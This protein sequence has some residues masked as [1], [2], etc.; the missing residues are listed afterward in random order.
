MSDINKTPEAPVGAN[1]PITTKPKKSSTTG[2]EGRSMNRVIVGIVLIA[3]AVALAV[4]IVPK[5]GQTDEVYGV[6]KVIDNVPE[7]VK[8][9]DENVNKY[10]AYTSTSD[11]DVAASVING[12][13]DDVLKKVVGKY[14]ARDIYAT[15]SRFLSY[16][17]LADNRVVTNDKVPE[18]KEL[19]G[20]AIPSIHGDIGFM[21]RPGDIIR[22]YGLK[23]L[24]DG[25][26]PIYIVQT[27]GTLV[28]THD[29]Y[30]EV[31]ELLQYVEIYR[32][33]D[34]AGID[35]SVSGATP[36]NMVI[37][38]TTEQV[39]QLVEAQNKGSIYLSLMSSG[40]KE[41]AAGFLKEQEVAI[42]RYKLRQETLD[43]IER[44]TVVVPLKS[45]THSFAENPLSYQKNYH[46]TI[47][48]T[49]TEEIETLGADGAITK[50]K[51]TT[52]KDS[53]PVLNCVAISDI[54]VNGKTITDMAA[55]ELVAL[56]VD[57]ISLGLSL[58][59]EQT[60]ALSALMKE[61]KVTVLPLT[62]S[63]EELEKKQ[64]AVDS[65]N[66]ELIIDKLIA[67][68]EAAEESDDK[69]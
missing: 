63:D 61:G 35:T 14:A 47:G 53:D 4:L 20:M 28:G 67:E 43:G 51:V 17:D 29:A 9:T 59:V 58:S 15:G 56:D 40:D 6:I 21:P 19:V 52:F 66:R 48:V 69:E 62:C 49:V 31:Y 65:A 23:E 11:R 41:K 68:K 55:E 36:T 25:S 33:L 13:K 54:Y 26:D 42:E 8:I 12:A 39:E 1:P 38:C 30:A 50:K 18:G 37:I 10:F 57:D 34:G 7:G 22:F 44:N 3:L 60:E 32:V 24:E 2:K 46:V 16:A 5:V 45:I 64:A 27:N